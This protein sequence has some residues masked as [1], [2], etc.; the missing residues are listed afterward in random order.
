MSC[1]SFFTTPMSNTDDCAYRWGM[2]PTQ[3]QYPPPLQVVTRTSILRP[4]TPS[5]P[6]RYLRSWA[7]RAHLVSARSLRRLVPSEPPPLSPLE[8][9]RFISACPA[10]PR[11]PS[12]HPPPHA[13]CV[14]SW[15]VTTMAWGYC[16]EYQVFFAT[17]RLFTQPKEPQQ[18]STMSASSFSFQQ[19]TGCNDIYTTPNVSLT[20][21][22]SGDLSVSSSSFIS[23]PSTPVD[24]SLRSPAHISNLGD[25]LSG[26]SGGPSALDSSA[27]NQLMR[28]CRHLESE[29]TKERQEH[30]TLKYVIVTCLCSQIH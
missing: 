26:T 13:S 4:L 8:L 6:P 24:I 17:S 15:H 1:V 29:L 11:P 19:H 18:T 9:E 23:G 12:I 16:Y 27:Y 25:Y 28:R 7:P 21:S 20:S 3:F 22:S 10:V 5:H 2:S 14:V 30:A